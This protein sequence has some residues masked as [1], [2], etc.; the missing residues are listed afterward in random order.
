MD[1][2]KDD[3]LKSFSIR[4]RTPEK[5]TIFHQLKARDIDEAIELSKKLA[6][7]KNWK[8]ISV[9]EFS[10]KKSEEQHEPKYS[11]Q[12]LEKARL[13]GFAEV[14]DFEK[15]LAKISDEE[16]KAIDDRTKEMMKEMWKETAEKRWKE[17]S[18]DYES[19]PPEAIGS[20]IN[21][22]KECVKD[23]EDVADEHIAH[24]DRNRK[25]PKVSLN[26]I[27]KGLSKIEEIYKKYSELLTDSSLNSLEAIAQ[28]N[29]KKFFDEFEKW[30]VET[31]KG[32]L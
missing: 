13:I 28:F 14:V 3:R 1:K 23:I 19:L 5:I 29:N 30:L 11:L 10:V 27:D 32:G 24:L 17:L 20:D 12:A 31:F 4:F 15:E 21:E 2:E 26:T 18:G 25:P 16:K 6:E 7:E 9:R 8:V 22:L